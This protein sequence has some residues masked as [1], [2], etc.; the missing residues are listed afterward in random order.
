M[1]PKQNYGDDCD[2][3]IS[4]FGELKDLYDTFRPKGFEIIGISI[5]EEKYIGN[6]KGII[7]QY[8]LPWTQFLDINGTEVSKLSILLYPF[9]LLCDAQGR[10][11]QIDMQPAQIAAFLKEKLDE[12]R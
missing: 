5:D 2:A 7:R 8:A 11:I 4:Q 6:W 12:R 1:F 10:I 9:N 3:C